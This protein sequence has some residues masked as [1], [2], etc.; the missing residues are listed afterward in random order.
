MCEVNATRILNES[1]ENLWHGSPSFLEKLTS[2][3]L[4]CRIGNDSWKWL[5]A[6]YIPNFS[7]STIDGLV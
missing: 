4:K 5:R 7:N 3:M 1:C 2:Y 6:I